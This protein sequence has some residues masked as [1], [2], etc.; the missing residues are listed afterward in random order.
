MR[1]STAKIA[2]TAKSPV[3]PQTL[4]TVRPNQAKPMP[5]PKAKKRD[6]IFSKSRD[7]REDRG[8]REM[9]SSNNDQSFH[10]R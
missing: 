3:F 9:K 5:A 10:A 2:A 1:G 6:N 7:V 8:T 4:H